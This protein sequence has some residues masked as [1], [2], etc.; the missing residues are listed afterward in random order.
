MIPST[1]V[2]E[3]K[4]KETSYKEVISLDLQIF[5]QKRRNNTPNTQLPVFSGQYPI[6]VE[7]NIH[8]FKQVIRDI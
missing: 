6:A 5:R 3:R 2:L 4:K 8:K 1:P 7:G